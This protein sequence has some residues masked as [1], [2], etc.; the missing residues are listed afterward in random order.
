MLSAADS[1][2]SRDA[3]GAANDGAG[4]D[5]LAIYLN[6]HLA[7]ATAGVDLARRT[8]KALAR[9]SAGSTLSGVAE[10]IPADRDALLA[11]MKA[12]DVPVRTYKV[13]LGWAAE[14]AGRLKLNGR[15]LG[16][17]P[18]SSL[19]ELEGL[20]VGIQG[21]IAGWRTLRVVAEHDD[22][23]DSARLDTLLSRATAQSELVETLRVATAE[24]LFGSA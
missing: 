15:L 13:Y 9:T 17:S 14:K 7:G 8:A 23:L 3:D 6:D 20:V 10:E 18:L 24:Q 16:R 5:L 12:L 22:R 1:S 21:K 11:M 2:G 19:V 4:P